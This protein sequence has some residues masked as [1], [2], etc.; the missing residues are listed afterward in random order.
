M[1]FVMIWCHIVY[2]LSNKLISTDQMIKEMESDQSK[3]FEF[4][5]KKMLQIIKIVVNVI[6]NQSLNRI[7]HALPLK[8][9]KISILVLMVYQFNYENNG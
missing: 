6:Y 4:L 7:G 9:I 5:K 2:L 3:G 8:L 1:V